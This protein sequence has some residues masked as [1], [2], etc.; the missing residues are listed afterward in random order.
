[1]TVSIFPHLFLKE[2]LAETTAAKPRPFEL[3]GTKWDIELTSW[4]DK[5]K[6]KT[7]KDTLIFSSRQVVSKGY[8]HKGRAPTR[9]SASARG[10]GVTTFA[11]MQTGTDETLFWKAEIYEDKTINGSLHVQ[12]KDGKVMEYFLSGKLAEGVLQ[13]KGEKTP[14]P[15]L[16]FEPLTAP[17][18]ESAPA[19][20]GGGAAK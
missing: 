15:L 13:R 4:T 3:D 16:S 2:S 12:S 17:A 20:R 9:Y 10:D 11:T 7:R 1:M 14:D 19:P 5:G 8:E 18:Q 6:K